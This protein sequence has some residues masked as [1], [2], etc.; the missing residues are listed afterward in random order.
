MR[1][2]ISAIALLLCLASTAEASHR[3]K[4]ILRTMRWAGCHAGL[5][6][7]DSVFTLRSMY[8]PF[9]HTVAIGTY[10]ADIPE[11]VVLTITLHEIGHCLQME[12]GTLYEMDDVTRELDADRR[13]ADMLCALHW[14][15]PRILHDLFVWAKQTVGYDG[16][17]GHGTLAERIAQGEVAPRCKKA[18]LQAPFMGWRTWLVG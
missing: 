11:E 4:G 6:T 15:G 1:R 3:D 2:L 8:I 17:P 7:D 18:A 5:L 10:T 14:D 13:A 12:D 9:I 16:D